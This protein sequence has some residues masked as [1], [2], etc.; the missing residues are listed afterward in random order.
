[1]ECIK[2]QT[3]KG[4]KFHLNLNFPAFRNFSENFY[5]QSTLSPFEL[6]FLESFSGIPLLLTLFEVLIT[7]KIGQ[8]LNLFLFFW[9][10]QILGFKIFITLNDIFGDIRMYRAFQTLRALKAHDLFS[11]VKVSISNI[12][13]FEFILFFLSHKFILYCCFFNVLINL[14]YLM[15]PLVVQVVYLHL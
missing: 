2:R 1:M 11:F 9:L 6:Y 12:E 7:Q 4:S 10:I 13:L 5:N 15:I 8:G 3:H 14:F